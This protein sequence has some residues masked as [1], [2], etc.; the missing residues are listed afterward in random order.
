MLQILTHL[1]CYTT[2]LIEAPKVLTDLLI[3][4]NTTRVPQVQQNTLILT[5]W[6][7]KKGL[8]D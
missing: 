3:A 8:V 2:T 5:H 6:Y 1:N 4:S 7:N